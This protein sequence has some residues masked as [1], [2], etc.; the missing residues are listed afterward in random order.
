MGAASATFSLE[1]S[2]AYR[3]IFWG[4]LIAGVMDLTA[5]F[6]TS[7]L[8]GVGPIRIMQSIAS[9][10]LGADAFKGGFKTAAL[11]VVLHFLIAT[12]ATSVYYAASRKLGLLVR[13]AIVCGIL[14]GVAVY[15][16]MYLIVLPNSAV[17]F[18]ISRT[19]SA[20]A[21]GL[22]IHIICVGLPI[23]LAVR[24]FSK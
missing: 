14:Y 18:K 7:G 20:V 9:G 4:G 19:L 2:N 16:F 13:Q 11:G 24:R 23:S 5:A 3:A 22:A 10:L 17:P 12:V 6:V 15:L 1:R 8:R 21:T